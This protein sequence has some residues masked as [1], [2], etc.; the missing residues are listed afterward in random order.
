[1]IRVAIRRPVAVATVYIGIGLLGCATLRNVPLELLPDLALPQLTVEARWP[2]ASP[3]AVEAFVTSPLEG[4]V[5]QIPGAE[6]V[7]SASETG[8]ATIEVAFRR[9]VDMDF[10]RLELSERLLSARRA[11]PR[12]VVPAI[13][14]YVPP[15]IRDQ[16]RPFL[17]YTLTGPPT[18]EALRAYVWEVLEPELVQVDGVRAIEVQGGREPLLEIALDP[19]RLQALG[20]DPHAVRQQIR[21]LDH[22]RAAGV[23]K[24][25]A[26]SRTVVVGQRVESLDALRALPLL[27]QPVQTDP[28]R[29]VRLRDVAVLND[30]LEEARHLYRVDGDPAVSFTVHKQV[31]TNVLAV[32]DAVKARLDEAA[33]VRPPGT[34]LILDADE[35]AVVRA[36]LSDLRTRA[37]VAAAVILAVLFLFLREVRAALV[38]FATIGFSI[39]LTLN[40]VY[41]GGLT[42]NVLTI[43]G[44]AVG[45]GL[46]V[47]NGIVVIE[48]IHRR[49]QRGDAPP[50]AAHRGASQVV[51]PITAATLTTVIAL[52]PFVYLQG[53]L[54]VYYVP[55]A[56]V[57]ALSLLASLVV[58]FTFVPAFA[59]R[60]RG[61]C[62][63]HAR[64]GAAP[65]D[66]AAPRAATVLRATLRRPVLTVLA[67]L[68]TLGGSYHVFDRHVTR[69]VLWS[70]WWGEDHHIDI[71]IGVPRGESLERVDAL[72]RHF[73]ELVREVPEVERFV[74]HV[75]PSFSQT[76][77]TFP[78]SLGATPL[79]AA[80]KE[81]LTA[82]SHRFG[83]MDVRVY[84]Y[85]PS[86]YGVAGSVRNYT[87]DVFGY[88][89]RNV[90]EIA[91]ELGARLARFSRIRD[92]D[93]NGRGRFLRDHETE[94]VLMLDRQR[95][96]LHG[97]SARDVAREVSAATRG[98]VREGELRLAGEDLRLTVAP[99]GSRHMDVHELEAMV[100][101]SRTGA[102]VR[103]RDVAQIEERAVPARIERE[104]QRYRRTVTYEFVGPPG[105]GDAVQK[106]VIASTYLPPGY[107]VGTGADWRWDTDERRQLHGVLVLSVLL[108]FMLTAALFES[109]RQPLIVLLS[110][111]MAFI[112]IF[113]IFA[114]TGA[115]F[116]REAYVGVIMAGG[117]VVNNAI[118]LMHHIN[119][120]RR[121]D[122]LA[123]E[124]AALR[125]TLDRARPILMTTTTTLLG[126]LPLVMF[127]GGSD[128]NIWDALAYALIGGL[129]SSTV[130]VLT[131]TPALYL[132]LERRFAVG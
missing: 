125:G 87:V 3:E 33:S 49:R 85:G 59:H 19:P 67:A 96:A 80:I 61:R 42:L 89:Y 94:L 36:Q 128:D 115:A 121:T 111:P 28:D 58:A 79:P 14:P 34:R 75:Y 113:V 4:V 51:L 55:F 106:S 41:L 50:N 30:T 56:I 53:E 77:V 18:P 1:M 7:V 95:L 2:G 70:T 37:L 64:D 72:A 103:L 88:D 127:G 100:V 47:D 16:Q 71:H 84:G 15:A 74:T 129:A 93:T 91:A 123:L 68:A 32:A 104:D 66:G 105:L 52:V 17:E 78:D 26:G 20:L 29:I 92:V 83:G 124:A 21:T 99:A 57:A 86:F 60:G 112:G 90:R 102:P 39:L 98:G 97:M 82:Y 9:G 24:M 8:M 107:S 81:Q 122:G 119:E 118:L 44:I 11:L 54:R 10:V 117:I 110:V 62:G 132:L 40:L 101:G 63:R 126:L 114:A 108:V 22:A 65:L 73:E 38:V 48:S 76:R 6:K 109:L 31:G 46:I 27:A 45:F 5:Q 13:T 35:S 23:V 116:T 69:E 131:V 12:D 43:M 25:G 130:L 120:L